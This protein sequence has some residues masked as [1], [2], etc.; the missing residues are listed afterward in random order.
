MHGQTDPSCGSLIFYSKNI[1][2]DKMARMLTKIGG[3]CAVL[4][5][6][7]WLSGCT[8]MYLGLAP[9]DDAKAPETSEADA[10]ARADIYAITPETLHVLASQQRADTDIA[11][12]RRDADAIPSPQAKGYT[13]K[14]AAR[15]VLHVTV[16]NHPELNNPA[17]QLSSDLAGRVVNDDGYFFYPYVG[18]VKAADRTVSDIRAELARRLTAYLTEPQVDVSVLQY[19]GRKAFVVGQVEKPGPV[20]ITDEP[21]FVTTLLT[22]VEGLKSNAD[23]SRAVLNRKG[24]IS[25]LDLYALYYKG[26]ISQN[27]LLQDGDIL[28]IPER[29]QDKV[30][31]LGEVRSPQ[32]RL[33][34]WGR[35]SLSDAL[36][37]A[38]GLDQVTARAS[39]VY[40]LRAA[41]SGRPEIWHLNASSP[42]ALVLADNFELR[43]RDVVFVDASAVT[44][45]SRVINQL[46]PSAGT[47]LQG[48][49]VA[50]DVRN[51]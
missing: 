12:A 39:Q 9:N 4:A 24:V 51:D 34:P 6:T 19:R 42:Q 18:R 47:L 22:Q 7:V 38:G 5:A 32:A 36:G 11:R 50:N 25:N 44:R 13:Y 48:A 21:L 41:D 15:D 8:G 16:W 26:D 14:V 17:G 30:F 45:W 43:A 37:D 49:S 1:V 31:V 28:N 35:Y 27:V 2:M 46:L 20:P 40:V 29:N 33:L 23:M 3:C 10:R